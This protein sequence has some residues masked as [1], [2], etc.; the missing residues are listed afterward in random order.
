[1]GQ[2]YRVVVA[3]DHALVRQSMACMLASAL[4][5]DAVGEASDG[6]EAVRLIQTHKPDVVVMDLSMPLLNGADAIQE[7]RQLSPN[8]KVVVLTAHHGEEWVFAA[9]R[10]GADAYVV[11]EAQFAELLTAVTSVL[12]GDRYLS[13]QVCGPVLEAYLRARSEAPP[14]GPSVSFDLLSSRE[15]QILKLIA[16]GHSIKAIGDHLNVSPKTVEKAR[17]SLS[18]KL[19]LKT[20]AQ[21]TAF[22]I[23]KGLVVR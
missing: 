13:P 23:E 14:A 22:A 5:L 18:K 7:I 1:M 10:A 16:E 20:V 3:D 8:T 21:L 9:L 12:R 11:K 4:Q 2:R 15:R 6:L 17:T 19:G